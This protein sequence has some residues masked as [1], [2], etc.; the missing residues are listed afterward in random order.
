MDWAAFLAENIPEP[1]TIT[2]EAYEG[3]G[4]YGD[5]YAAPVDVEGCVIEHTRR[6]VQV[7]TQDAAGGV[8]ISSTTVYAPPATVLPVGSRVTLPTGAVTKV[9][10]ASYQDPHGH[11]L[12][13]HWELALE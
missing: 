1:H 3:S 6:R 7:Q 11:P 12:P 2:G 9:L 10:A 5:T 4:A 13:A 8:V